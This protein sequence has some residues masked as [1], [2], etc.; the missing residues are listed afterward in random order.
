VRVDE[1]RVGK[2]HVRQVA[3]VRLVAYA[4]ADDPRSA[5]LRVP[6]G[7]IFAR[8]RR[9]GHYH[10]R[11]TTFALVHGAWHGAW[12]WE[13]LTPLLQQAGHD[14]VAMD[15]PIEDGSASFDTYSDVVCSALDGP[16][17]D[18][19]AVGHSYGG[20]VIPLVAARRRVRH[21]V[22]VC[23]DIPDI[24]RSLD[25]QLC[26]EPDMVNPACYAGF[27]L[28]EQSRFVWVDDALARTMMY[29]DCDELTASAAIKRLRP[30]SPYANSLPCSLTEFP[31]VS[32][33]SVVCGDDQLVGHEWAKRVARDRLGADL[34]EL[35]GSHSP[36]LSR[37]SALADELLRIANA[38]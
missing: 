8:R 33:S 22:Y 13:R 23:A 34:I 5:G 1:V 28:D 6:S 30:Q 9:S 4:V 35:P 11:V 2:T 17:D 25:D 27:K 24:G 18:V 3:A 14:V 26:D 36:F 38:D 7:A 15:L 10:R 37:P 16:D 20:M 31:A 29:A 12:C 32:C 19:V 21:L